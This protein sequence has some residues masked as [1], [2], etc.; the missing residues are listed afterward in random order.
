MT[1]KALAPKT[2]SLKDY[3]VPEEKKEKAGGG[4][5][6]GKSSAEKVTDYKRETDAIEKRTR[7]F[8][9][10]R[11]A[12]GKSALE[13]AQ[14]EGKFR[15]MEAAQKAGVPVTQQLTQDVDRL[16]LAYARA[17]VALGR[18]RGEATLIRG[19]VTAGRRHAVRWL[20]G[21]RA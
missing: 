15:L 10:E 19:G 13:V 20:Q 1:A 12:I 11:E 5:G 7:A 3:K 18:S 17:K 2:I 9:S 21:C 8:D 16:S 6:G 4:G 14:A